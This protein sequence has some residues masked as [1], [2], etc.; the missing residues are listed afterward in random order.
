LRVPEY[1][2][3]T[4]TYSNVVITATSND[5]I[6]IEYALGT[7]TSMAAYKVQDLEFA[8]QEELLNAGLVTG[9]YAKALKR[10][11]AKRDSAQR[12]AEQK[13]A[14]GPLAEPKISLEAAKE[15]SMAKL[16]AAQVQY[17]A[18]V[19]DVQMELQPWLDKYGERIIYGIIAAAGFL[20]FLRLCLYYRICKKATGEGTILVFVPIIRWFVLVGASG[21]SKHWLLVPAFAAAASF[22]PPVTVNQYPWAPLAYLI[23]LG[24]LWLAT[25]ILYIVW[26]VR[27]CR[28]V[29]CSG[30]LA[31]LMLVPVVEF[32]ALFTLASSSGYQGHA[33]GARMKKPAMAV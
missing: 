7:A 12:R 13:A 17:Q 32:I 29:D 27:L 31:V 25:G 10:A 19:N 15:E 6:L 24:V 9:P 20:V 33:V 23:F 14:R 16:V 5:R 2:V 30:W 28:A 11:I 18:E 21:M 8:K 4:N 1:S 22:L 26:C 3:G